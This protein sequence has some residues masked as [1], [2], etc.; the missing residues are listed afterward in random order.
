MK[1]LN[2]LILFLFCLSLLC[3][4]ATSHNIKDLSSELKGKTSYTTDQKSEPLKPITDFEEV[5]H[6]VQKNGKLPKNFI[7][8]KEAKKLGWDNKKGNL[9]EV[10]PGKS[11][12]GDIY[13]NREKRLPNKK[14]RI[15]YEADIN[16]VS[17]YRGKDRLLYSND[18]LFYKTTDHYKTF[19]KIP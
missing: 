1:K 2:F 15:W 14:G 13:Y 9:S 18:R 3:G 10:A 7:T 16:Y 17:G 6:Y 12:G 5:K 4:C 11:I 19:I 8:K